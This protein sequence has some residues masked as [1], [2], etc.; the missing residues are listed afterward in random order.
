[1]TI[2]HVSVPAAEKSRAGFFRRR[3]PK[4][5]PLTLV[6]R[7]AEIDRTH[8]FRRLYVMGCGR[9]GTWL[10]TALLSTFANV[11]IFPKE[12]R[13]ED[14]GSFVTDRQMLVLKRHNKAYQTIEEIPDA[15]AIVMI[16]RHPFAVLTSHNPTTGYK[17]HVTPHRWL[18]EMLALQYLLDTHRQPAT[19]V[20]YEDLVADPDATQRLLASRL[21]LTVQHAARDAHSVFAA[22]PEAISAMHGLRPIDTASLEA[23]RQS[24]EKMDYLRSIR[25]RLGRLLD[26]VAGEF[27]YD[28]TL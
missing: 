11:D 10:L 27:R 28:V 21:G 4:P 26:W 24:A 6:Q 23:Y 8:D 18:G 3:A 12:V 19:I 14:F 13:V 5:P 17:Y 15:V 7:L 2:R 9:S 20:R 25:P 1:V 22:S 16:V